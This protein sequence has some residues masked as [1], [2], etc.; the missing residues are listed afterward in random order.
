M[1]DFRAEDN[2][3]PA[4]RHMKVRIGATFIAN[5]C[6]AGLSFLAGVVV[7]HGLGASEYG[8]LSFLLSSFAAISQLFEMG[9]SSA[10]YTFISKRQ[11]PAIFYAVYCGWLSFQFFGT[12]VAVGVVSTTSILDILWLGNPRGV[13]LSAFLASFLMTQG[14]GTVVQLGEAARETLVVQAVGIAQAVVHLVVIIIVTKIG[15]LTV[16]SVL[17]ILA[18]EHFILVLACGPRFLRLNTYER[19]QGT[20]RLAT[21]I[22]EFVSYCRPLAIYGW[23]GFA[24]AFADRWLLQHFGGS[25]QQG[26]FAVGQQFANVSLIATT[27][28]LKVFWKE[29]AEARQRQDHERVKQLFFSV[30]RG[31]FYGTACVSCLLIPYGRDILKATVGHEYETA[32]PALSLLLLY[33][34]YQS[35][36]QI[37]GTFFYACGETGEYVRISIVMMAIGA[38]ITYFL[39]AP[40]SAILPGLGLGATG[41]ALRLIVHAVIEVNMKLHRIARMNRWPYTYW[42]QAIVIGILLSMG[43]VCK[44]IASN[45]VSLVTGHTSPLMVL[46]FSAPIYIVLSLCVLSCAPTLAGMTREQLIVIVRAIQSRRTERSFLVK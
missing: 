45:V 15:W 36:G 23:V 37:G 18:I 46:G 14:W 34:I 20:E 28:I 29:V 6:R 33:A 4:R 26:F 9:T 10:F 19:D 40:S 42:Y 30:S 32:Y 2:R 24:Y 16:Q 11:K 7:A 25:E 1:K 17:W 38:L 31:L 13:I 8:D 41:L 44:W 43:Y 35:L 27:S 22:K 39:L 12:V 5:V 21:V 3:E